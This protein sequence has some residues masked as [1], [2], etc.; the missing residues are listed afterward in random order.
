MA[1]DDRVS[2]V[3]ADG[4]VLEHAPVVHAKGSWELPLGREEL[5]EK[6]LDCATRRLDRAHAQ[7]LFEQL[8]NIMDIASVR[9]LRLTEFRQVS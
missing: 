6:F 1:P 7:A 3:L 8:W 2:V 9:D 5:R 4:T